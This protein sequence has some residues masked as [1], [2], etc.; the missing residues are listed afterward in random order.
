LKETVSN[1][2]RTEEVHKMR[3]VL[4]IVHMTNAHD[5]E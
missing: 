1:Q 3:S 5:L 4:S 2:F